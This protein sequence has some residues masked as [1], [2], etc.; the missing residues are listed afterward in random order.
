MKLE[1]TT[2]EITKGKI[3]VIPTDT[4]YGVIGSALKPE[5]VERVYKVRKRDPKKPMIVLISSPQELDQFGITLSHEQRTFLNTVW[6]GPT[7]VILK[8]AHP[9]LAHIHRGTETIAFRVPNKPELQNLLEQT[10]S[11]VAPSANLEGESPSKTID[12]ARAYFG[13]TVDFYVDAGPLTGSPSTLVQLE[14]DGSYKTLR[15]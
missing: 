1:E 14:R 3:G 2:N 5:V 8:C 4:L 7:S 12:N 6:P 10:G 15:K 13:E 9:G 11:V